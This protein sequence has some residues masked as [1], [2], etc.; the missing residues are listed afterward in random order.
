M[1]S[2]EF[3][4]H[5]DERCFLPIHVYDTAT[6]RPIAVLLRPGKTE[7]GGSFWRCRRVCAT[8]ARSSEREKERL[9]LVSQRLLAG[10]TY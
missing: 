4:A 9:A 3:N 7:R 8:C 5:Y 6:S 2:A 1:K 10:F